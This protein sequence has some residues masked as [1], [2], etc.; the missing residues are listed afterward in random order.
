M[1]ETMEEKKAPVV[2]GIHI[3]P[4]AQQPMVSLEEVHA[5]PGRGLEGDRYFARQR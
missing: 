2:V 3:A 4:A 1:G 5:V